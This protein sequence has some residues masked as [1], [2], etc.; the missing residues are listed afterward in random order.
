ME[1]KGTF[2]FFVLSSTVNLGS[3]GTVPVAIF[4]TT[5][6]DATTVNP[7]SVTLTS[8]PVQLKGKG[9]PMASFQD[10][11][12]DSLLDLVVYIDTQALQ[13]SDTDTE[14]VLEGQTLAGTPIQGVNSI[15]VVP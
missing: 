14:A 7:V 1:E 3:S 4:S 13:L 9:T 10:V 2:P 12:G 8:A 5:T 6:F 15:R 11:D